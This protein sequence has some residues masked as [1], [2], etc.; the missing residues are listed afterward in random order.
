MLVRKN[1]LTIVGRLQRCWLFV[2]R[3]PVE[4]VR[5]VLPPPLEP[6]ARSGYAFWN[7]VV[8]QIHAMRPKHLPAAVGV[9]YWHVAYR[10]YVQLPLPT[11]EVVQGLYFVRSDCDRWLMS[12]LGNLLTDFRFHVASIVVREEP[13]AVLLRVASKHAPAQARLVAAGVPQLAA[14]SPFASA[15]EAAAFLAYEP[16]GIALT[17]AGHA[18]I[19]H[20]TRDER[21]WRSHPLRVESAEWTFFAGQDVCLESCYAVEPIAY[22]WDRGRV[23]CL[24]V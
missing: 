17:P 20:V 10:L 3:A 7:I 12:L 14:G 11:G 5:L 24:H 18:N 23:Y 13:D 9:S 1:P 6:L 4:A 19:I 8:C 15:Q 16:H 2:Y 21:A 22:Q